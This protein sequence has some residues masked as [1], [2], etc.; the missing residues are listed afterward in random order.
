MIEAKADQE[1]A[2]LY[3]KT[4]AVDPDFY[5]FVRGLEASERVLEE[6]GVVVLE[7]DASPFETLLETP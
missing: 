1:A 3:A 6:G 5:A 4:Y 2:M 7:S